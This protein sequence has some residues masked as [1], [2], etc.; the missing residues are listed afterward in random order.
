M[1][2]ASQLWLTELVFCTIPICV[3]LGIGWWV[4]G[5]ATTEW[6]QALWPRWIPFGLLSAFLGGGVGAITLKSY[7]LFRNNGP[8]KAFIKGQLKG[9]VLIIALFG[10]LN[11]ISAGWPGRIT[12][13]MG[14][15]I[16]ISAIASIGI[17]VVLLATLMAEVLYRLGF[18]SHWRP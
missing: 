4:L 7:P 8:D 3:G 10:G 9:A 18:Y 1:S 17:S 6:L 14:F 2:K 11:Q 5:P 16:A 12:Y 15:M 13:F